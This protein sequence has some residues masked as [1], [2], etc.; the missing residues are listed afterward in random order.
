M[1]AELSEELI[2]TL[3]I[4]D[5]RLVSLHLDNS[6]DGGL[7]LFLTI[8]INEEELMTPFSRIGISQRNVRLVFSE[9]YQAVSNLLG[10][11]APAECISTWEI[12]TTS[13]LLDK[14]NEFGL[15]QDIVLLHHRIRLS[16]GSTIE[17]LSTRVFAEGTM[18]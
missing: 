15:A 1:R 10:C 16:A 12:L 11:V 6:P 7:V 13:P 8:E 4:H 18:I 3:P 5:A 14:F 17:A 2:E 9:C